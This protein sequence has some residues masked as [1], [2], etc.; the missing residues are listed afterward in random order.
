MRRRT[1]FKNY[2]RGAKWEDSGWSVMQGDPYGD[3]TTNGPDVNTLIIGPLNPR[4][5]ITFNADTPQYTTS[6]TVPSEEGR[7]RLRRAVG[8]I[9]IGLWPFSIS[10]QDDPSTDKF[11]GLKSGY[12]GANPRWG[13]SQGCM[14]KLWWFWE[15]RAS[16]WQT[17]NAG[18]FYTPNDTAFYKQTNIIKMYWGH[19][20]PWTPM[21]HKF[22]MKFG[23]GTKLARQNGNYQLACA[24]TVAGVDSTLDDGTQIRAIANGKAFCS[25][26]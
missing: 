4:R 8:Q 25:S 21:I 18:Q 3:P 24:A 26:F 15:D 17:Y 13:E 11:T 9:S 22:D 2:T 20:T 23:L 19:I 5:L 14:V 10:G 12:D 16:A 7:L 1:S 6:S